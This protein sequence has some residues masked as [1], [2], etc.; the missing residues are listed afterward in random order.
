MTEPQIQKVLIDAGVLLA[1]PDIIS[2]IRSKQNVPVLFAESIP[3]LIDQR[4]Q[5]TEQGRNA[6]RV[7]RQIEGDRAFE[8][9]AFPDGSSVL[10]GDLLASFMFD[11]APAYIFKRM[12][13]MAPTA[14]TRLL[15]VANQYRM[16]LVTSDDQLLNQAKAN[17]VACHRWPPQPQAKASNQSASKPEPMQLTA[18][19]LYRKPTSAA[20]ER[21]PFKV[22]PTIGDVVSTGSAKSLRL[23]REISKG[24]EGVI[25]ETCDPSLVCKVYHAKELTTLRR[26]KIELMVT[27]KISRAD[28]CW[29]TEV[30]YNQHSEFIGYVM[31]RAEG[32]TMFSGIFI[33]PAFLKTFPTWG[34]IDLVNL[35]L[36][37]LEQIRFLHSLNILVGDINANNLLVTK[38]STKLWMVD[39]D[40]FQIEAFPCPVG[41]I[42]FTAPEI[43]GET[44]GNFMRTK[45]HE[46]FSV[47]TML[48]M[49]LFPGKTPYSQQ[50]GGTQAEN[51]KARNFPYRDHDNAENF[52]GENA[53]EGDWQ[54]I[55]NHLKADVRK[56]FQKTFR[57]GERISVDRWINLLESYRSSIAKK[58]NGNEVFPTSFYFVR[59]PVVVPC[60]R[61]KITITASKKY[62]EKQAKKGFKPWCQSCH[63]KHRLTT[64]ARESLKKT[65]EAERKNQGR[66]AIVQRP[67]PTPRPIAPQPQARPQ[68]AVQTQPMQNRAAST[69]QSRPQAQQSSH[70]PHRPQSPTPPRP[71]AAP[72]PRTQPNARKRKS[73]VAEFI[74]IVLRAL[75]SK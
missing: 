20:N 4:A 42:A 26:Q 71:Q 29:P 68:P 40:S 35:C 52:S 43:Q 58:A 15:E 28:I 46:L 11:G 32:K 25:Y 8:E 44:Y 18:F 48:F 30:V 72:L 51:I 73:K 34:R 61:C 16:A 23:V 14:N 66:P 1:F 33:K 24:G 2:K 75:F 7:L 53:P 3:I 47:A 37:F 50:N 27:R 21:L 38:D 64:M 49:I 54:T 9:R 56:A 55:W 74:G 19:A 69:I 67:A 41:T 13:F 70:Q 63:K 17:G 59:D 57:E 45:E 31:P 60:G 65:Q 39:T 36:A 62:V 10:Q 5:P 6:E 22:L 12:Q